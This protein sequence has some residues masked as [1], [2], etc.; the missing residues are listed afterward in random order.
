MLVLT[1]FSIAARCPRTGMVGVAVC[2]AVPA[3]GS[4][5]PFVKSQVGAIATQSFVNPYLGI[6]GLRLLEQGLS[7]QEVLEQLLAGD[8]GRD[9]RQLSVVDSRGNAAAFTGQSCVPWHGHRVGD[10]YAVAANMMVD[11]TTVSAMAQAFESNGADELPE[12]L[13]KALEAGD[14]TGGDYR[15]RQSAALLVY[16]TEEY[17]YCS[18]RVDEHRHPVAE[19]R[20]IFEV[21]RQ[22]LFPFIAML[23]TRAHPQGFADV[24]NNPVGATLLKAVDKR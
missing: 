1:T 7:A 23:P 22:Q 4:L 16:H 9:V 17:P 19:L 24:T 20:R 18:L 10:G 6:D 2:T 12:R 11:E 13:L 8:P 5:C 15:G 21:G 14:A 3:V